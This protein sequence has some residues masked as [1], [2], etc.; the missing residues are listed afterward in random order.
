[1][2][3]AK[4]GNPEAMYLLGRMYQYG[5]GVP[6]NFEEARSWYAKGA[7][8]NNPLSQLSL[9]FYTTQAKGPSKIFLRLLNGI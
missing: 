7:E 2:Q 3:S 1:M 6:E 8:K 9:G 5:N 4:E